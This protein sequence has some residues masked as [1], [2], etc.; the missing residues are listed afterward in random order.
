MYYQRMNLKRTFIISPN[1]KKLFQNAKELI[2]LFPKKLLPKFYIIQILIIIGILLESVSIFSIIPF[3]DSFNSSSDNKIVKF[4]ELQSFERSSLFLIFIFFLIL[5]NLFQIMVNIIITKFGFD[6]T[7]YIKNYLYELILLKKYNYFL[8]RETSFFNSLFLNETWRI[9]NGMIDP[10]L[11][12]FSQLL[13]IIVVLSGL[14]LYNFYP[15]LIILS[16]VSVFYIIYFF[17]I[18]KKI[19]LNSKKISLFKLKLIQQI[20]DNFSTIKENIFKI[21]KKTNSNKFSN[22]VGNMFGVIMYN[23]V[24]AT[25]IKN[26]F[27]IFVCMILIGILFINKNIDYINLITANGVLFFAAYKLVPSFHKVYASFLSFIDSSNALNVV[28]NELNGLNSEIY[29]FNNVNKNSVNKVQINDLFFSYDKK[30]NVI[31]NINFELKSNATIGICGE[32]GSGKTTFV[33]ILCGLI[34]PDK[35]IIKVN[36]EKL[37]K[38]ET[39]IRSFSYCGQKNFLI[40]D[41][42]KNNISFKTDISLEEEAEI[43]NLLKI[44]ELD[45]FVTNL[46]NK[47]NTLISAENGIKL[48]SGQAQRICIARC[49]FSR[50]NFL[51]F[52][53]SFNN[54]DGV[55]REKILTNILENFNNKTIIMITHDLNLLRK[56]DQ[57]LLFKSGEIL[58]SSNYQNLI[59]KSDYFRRLHSNDKE[60]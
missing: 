44:V 19:Y 41:T 3:L 23:Q 29:D 10:G 17:I 32:S 45:N 60:K 49:L 25:I 16:L 35:G 33:D 8:K 37:V 27:E 40:E 38:E 53:E 1:I 43:E 12:L 9:N 26:I 56:F 7:K 39:L 57:I 5:S 36:D 42:I 4:F 28:S 58:E 13:L 11:R 14:L 6:V 46:D 51:I 21:D 50:K 48:S 52:D 47:I 15:T 20:T 2:K 22:T 30:K 55:N 54:L 24:A 59:E 34:K 18:S 31:K